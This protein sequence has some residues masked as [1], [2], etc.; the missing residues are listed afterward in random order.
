MRQAS[1]G[2]N[3]PATRK[4]FPIPAELAEIRALGVNHVK[5]PANGPGNSCRIGQELPPMNRFWRQNMPR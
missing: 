1:V 4:K 5:I 3:F 2:S